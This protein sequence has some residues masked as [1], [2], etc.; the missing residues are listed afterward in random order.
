MPIFEYRC[1]DC[2]NL[3]EK[4]QRDPKPDVP[5]PK[6]SGPAQRI[7]SRPSVS[8]PAQSS[9]GAPGGSGFT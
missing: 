6:C 3:I 2:G 7:V 8:A 1:H 5:C 4:I 9:C